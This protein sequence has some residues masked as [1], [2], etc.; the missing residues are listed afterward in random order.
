MNDNKTY[1]DFLGTGWSFPPT[2]RKS[3]QT[4]DL[5]KGVADILS[6]LEILLST[7]AGE[8]VMRPE[9][10]ANLNELQF[11]SLNTTF[12]TYITEKVKDAILLNEPRV[13]VQTVAIDELNPEEGL[14]QLKVD[15]TIIST[16]SRQ[17]FV[18]PFYKDGIPNT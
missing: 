3:T 2:F 10:G 13:N 18:F 9:Y 16:N 6:S 5:V 7:V 8:R 15:Y 11:E 1:T 14:L 12:I 4:V 17:N